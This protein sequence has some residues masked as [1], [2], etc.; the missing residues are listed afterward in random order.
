MDVSYDK[1]INVMPAGTPSR[2]QLANLSP[3]LNYDPVY[4][5][6]TSQP[7]FIFP[8]GATEQRR[9]FDFSFSQIGTS[10]MIGAS[11]GGANGFYNGLKSTTLLGQTG[12]LRRTQ[13]LN[14]VMKRGAATANTLGVIAVMYSAFGVLLSCI[15]TDDEYNTLA[16]ATA[17]G[18]LFRSTSGL[19]KCA[20]GGLTGFA[21]ASA[22]CLWTNR[23]RLQ[24]LR[25]KLPLS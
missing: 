17:S 15:R 5:P 14:H 21:A 1:D 22:Y 23:D 11:I 19:K 20:L 25:Q 13:L 6:Q 18:L 2:Q 12:K 9:R 4:L 3:Y 7:E 24:D 8:D 10:C 16:A